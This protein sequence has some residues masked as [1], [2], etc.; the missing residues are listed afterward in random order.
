MP[1]FTRVTVAWE[2]RRADV[3][4]A[5]D[6]PLAGLM[7]QL[8]D[9]V[10]VPGSGPHTL[11]RVTGDC[12]DLGRDCVGN[13]VIDGEV[14][15]V[16]GWSDAPAPPVVSDVTGWVAG[17]TET[18]DTGFAQKVRRVA[19]VVIAAGATLAAGL[20]LPWGGI[21]DGTRCVVMVGA[22]VVLTVAGVV[23]GRVGRRLVAVVACAVAAGL[24]VPAGMAVAAVTE[25]PDPVL[26]T[27]LAAVC[28]WW[29]VAGVGVGL[30]CRARAWIVGA[31]VC[32]PVAVLG[33]VLVL[34][35]VGPDRV[36][37]VLGVVSAVVLGLVP[38]WALSLSG[39]TGLD[40]LVASG[41]AVGRERVDRAWRDA[42]GTTV[43]CAAGTATTALVAAGVLSR[44][45]DRWDVAL[46]V[47]V[48]L[49][50][51]LRVRAFPNRVLVA[52]VWVVACA[53]VIAGVAGLPG[54][55]AVAG[56][57]MVAGVAVLVV[58]ARV[59]EHVVIRVR[60]VGNV[61]E[62]LGTAALLP[63]LL[64]VFGVYSSLLGAF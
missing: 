33:L 25:S 46:A 7:P 52:G 34:A 56:L 8:V 32:G 22:V 15:R 60:G 9:L 19:G 59:P 26:V 45:T 1:G 36:W 17:R 57:V 54:W 12:V 27:G 20:A 18:V 14:L 28:V 5:S 37:A 51:V 35:G 4:I 31:V 48:L 62:K 42:A 53:A 29:L 41:D 64:G 55:W 2:Q 13:N 11:A 63:V 24:G 10:G 50:V 43:V 49:V 44:G 21:G 38:G 39:L 6:Q 40:D 23:V 47:V 30:G 3:V 58:L 16:V 61:V